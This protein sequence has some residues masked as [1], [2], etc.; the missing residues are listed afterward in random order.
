MGSFSKFHKDSSTHKTNCSFSVAWSR[1]NATLAGFSA[2]VAMLQSRA[3]GWVCS[4]TGIDREGTDGRD[5]GEQGL[6]IHLKGE[7]LSHRDW[8]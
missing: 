6:R 8:P 2:K 7:E 5:T 3:Q 1:H 4:E